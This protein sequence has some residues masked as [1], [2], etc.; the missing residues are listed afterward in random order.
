[1]AKGIKPKDD[2]KKSTDSKPDVLDS[3]SPIDRGKDFIPTGGS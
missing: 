2:T 3:L 1:M